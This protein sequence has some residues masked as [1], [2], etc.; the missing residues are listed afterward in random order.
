MERPVSIVWFE[1]CYLGSLVVGLI[2]GALQ[3]PQVAAK[4]AETP[5][6]DQ[7]GPSFFPA[8]MAVGFALSIAVTLLLWFFTARK[9]AVVTKWIITVLLVLQVLNL[10]FAAV[11]H[12]LPEGLG[13]VIAIVAFVLDA[14]AVWQLF[15]PDAEAWFARGTTPSDTAAR[16]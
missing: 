10:G 1:R 11:M 8:M 16:L 5:G 13:G 15:R 4:M 14:V 6:A 9:G 2:G 3:Y 12:R 7:F